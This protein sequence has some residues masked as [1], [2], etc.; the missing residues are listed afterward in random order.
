MTEIPMKATAFVPGHISAFFEPVYVN[1][2]LDRTGSRGAGL[3][4]SLGVVSQ[5]VVNRRT[6]ISS[7]IRISWSIA[8]GKYLLFPMK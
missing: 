1:Q 8:W 5:V 3:N 4:I 7:S 2:N 6:V